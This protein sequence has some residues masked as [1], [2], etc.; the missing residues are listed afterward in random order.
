[1]Q[2][3]LYS[4]SSL[5]VFVSYLLL[6]S[7]ELMGNSCPLVWSSGE[8]RNTYDEWMMW[9]FPTSS[10]TGTLFFL[11]TSQPR[12]KTHTT[13]TIQDVTK[14]VLLRGLTRTQN[15]HCTFCVEFW[16]IVYFFTFL[17]GSKIILFPVPMNNMIPTS[18][19]SKSYVLLIVLTNNV[20]T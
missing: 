8:R 6:V 9:E 4:P 5:C 15:L 17:I 2:C 10:S 7:Y 20:R 18:L 13:Q 14:F 16:C 11:L 3:W 1:M 12:E 19:V